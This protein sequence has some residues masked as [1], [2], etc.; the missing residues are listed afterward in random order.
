[1]HPVL[2]GVVVERQQLVEVVGELRDRLGKLR[3][4]G[5][6]ERLRGVQGVAAVLG[7]PDLG[8]G[9]LRSGMC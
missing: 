7:V 8:Q 3:P 5:G 4:V 1:M 2:G 9:L 6:I